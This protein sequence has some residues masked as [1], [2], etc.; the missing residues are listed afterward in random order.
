VLPPDKDDEADKDPGED[1]PGMGGPAGTDAADETHDGRRPE[2]DQ[3]AAGSDRP[4]GQQVDP[5]DVMPLSG[6]MREREPAPTEPQ[7]PAAPPPTAAPEPS[8]PWG[9]PMAGRREPQAIERLETAAPPPRIEEPEAADD[10][11]AAPHEP[12]PGASEPNAERADETG[13]H[14]AA[15]SPPAAAPP[16]AP[17][18]GGGFLSGLVAAILGGLIGAGGIWYYLEQQEPEGPDPALAAALEE[19]DA[20]VAS[21]S[22]RLTAIESDIGSLNEALSATDYSATIDQLRLENEGQLAS[23]GEGLAR[24]EE[25]LGGIDAGLQDVRERLDEADA[26]IAELEARPIADPDTATEVLRSEVEAMR[27]EVDAATEAAR[28]QV[29]TMRNDLA[30][31]AEATQAEIAAAEARAIELETE[32]EERARAAEEEAQAL[33]RRTE[34]KAAL[35]QIDAALDS[36]EPYTESLARLQTNL[37]EEAGVPVSLYNPADTGVPTLSELRESY[38]EAAREALGASAVAAAEGDPGDRLMAFL[39]TQTQARSLSP[40]EGSSADA[41]LSRAEA[42]LDRGDVQG[43]LAEIETLPADGRAAMEDWIAEARLRTEAVAAAES[44]S[45]T[46]N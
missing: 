21:Q 26:R 37:G 45:A 30:A 2:A 4:E 22:E 11:P 24:I 19:R 17:R 8:T 39:R 16:P 40:Q 43:A 27:Q 29:E 25:R 38:P 20:E 28:A 15:S 12:T 18:S 10:D 31:A 46:F 41:I 13:T 6:D 23:V 9:A 7:G 14:D 34:A 1:G 32:A 35:L 33:A 5:D 44:L 36:G 42:A 3:E